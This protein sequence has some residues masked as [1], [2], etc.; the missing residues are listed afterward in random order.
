M[1]AL[2]T[3]SYAVL[4]LLAVQ[5]MT[6][7]QL[8]KQMERSLRD[9]W[10][11]AESVIYEEPKK[12]AASGHVLAT[13]DH[14]GRRR[15]TT[16]TITRKGRT[17]LRK[18]L[19]TTGAAPSVE[20]EALLKVAFADHG[21]LDSMQRN[22]AAIAEMADARA[23]YITRRIEEYRTT[24]GPFPERLPVT[25]LIARFHLEQAAAA[26]RWARWAADEVNRW[27]GVTPQTGATVP[28]WLDAK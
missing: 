28:R 24:G 8:A 20:F 9:V 5:P 19:A 3:T 4:S 2:T 12:L 26:Q 21:D 6:T 7:Y 16:Y 10:P 1:V 25:T 11:R 15:S 17:A 13:V 18:W 27:G 23:D 22:I 14:N